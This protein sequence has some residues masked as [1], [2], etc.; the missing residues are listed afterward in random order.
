PASF[1][2][3][4]AMARPCNVFDRVIRFSVRKKFGVGPGSTSKH[5]APPDLSALVPFSGLGCQRKGGRTSC[6]PRRGR[7]LPSSWSRRRR[8]CRRKAQASVL[9]RSSLVHGG[10]KDEWSSGGPKPCGILRLQE[11][12]DSRSKTSSRS[13]PSPPFGLGLPGC[14]AP[15]LLL[16]LLRRRA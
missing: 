7:R 1:A 6:R 15:R 3:S 4:N 10:T 16:P 12:F 11:S 13:L 2:R 9:V 5:S 14:R 8:G